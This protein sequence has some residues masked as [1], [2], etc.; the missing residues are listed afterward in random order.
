MVA[1]EPA[2]QVFIGG[3][4]GDLR[5]A[6]KDFRGGAVDVFAFHQHGYRLAASVQC[7]VD[8]L[9][10]FGNEHALGRLEAV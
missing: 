8:D 9:G 6:G 10:A 4:H 5:A 7:P 1:G 2:Q 3:I